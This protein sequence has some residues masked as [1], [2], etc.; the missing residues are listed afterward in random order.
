M[1]RI[2]PLLLAIAA[3]ACSPK[4]WLYKG[5]HE[6]V[7]I[8]YR[9]NHPEGKPSELL[10]RL[11]NTS[12]EDKRLELVIDLYYQGRTVETLTTYTCVRTGQTLSGKLNGIWFTPEN[13]TTEQIKSPDVQVEM[14]RTDITDD[15]CQ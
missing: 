7:D 1:K 9:W 11:Q 10:L 3:I 4:P 15:V 2:V 5:L 8:S 12:A 6:G 14:T 13:L